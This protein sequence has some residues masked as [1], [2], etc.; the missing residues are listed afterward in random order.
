MNINFKKVAQNETVLARIMEGR[1]KL[2]TEDLIIKYP[3]GFII[4]EIERVILPKGDNKFDIFWAFHI[5]DTDNFA[6]AGAILNKIFEKYLQIMEGN[7]DALYTEFA[8][9][10]GIKVRLKSEFTKSSKKPITT[11]EVID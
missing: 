4:D 7:Y 1:V 3:D 6:F 11:V 9:S 2:S 10:G 8:Q 5:K